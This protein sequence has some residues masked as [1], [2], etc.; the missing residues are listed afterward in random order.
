MQDRQCW[1]S[2]W[3]R[4]GDRKDAG[5][6]VVH[7]DELN[8]L[9]RREG[10]PLQMLPLERIVRYLIWSITPPWIIGVSEICI[11]PLH[12][13]LFEAFIYESMGNSPHCSSR[14]SRLPFP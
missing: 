9:S 8:A 3:I 14:P 5:I 10:S 12:Q 13:S 4:N 1:L 6:L 7:V 11:L 2:S